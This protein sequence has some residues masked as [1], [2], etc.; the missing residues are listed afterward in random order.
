MARLSNYV[1]DI[2]SSFPGLDSV[3]ALVILWL[4]QE[5][6]YALNQSIILSPGTLPSIPIVDTDG[7]PS[8]A[9]RCVKPVFGFNGFPIGF[10]GNQGTN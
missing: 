1:A 5:W 10:G 2:S 6:R 9:P 8:H 3:L 4:N 7:I